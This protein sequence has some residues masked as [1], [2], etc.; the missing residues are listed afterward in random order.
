MLFACFHTP[1]Q[2]QNFVLIPC[3]QNTV[4]I[5]KQTC[6]SVGYMTTSKFHS[7]FK[8]LHTLSKFHCKMFLQRLIVSIVISYPEL[9][10]AVTTFKGIPFFLFSLSLRQHEM[11]EIFK[12]RYRRP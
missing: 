4:T 11:E 5:P 10:E 12:A 8:N 9:R 1:Y 2:G 3:Q 7:A 6:P